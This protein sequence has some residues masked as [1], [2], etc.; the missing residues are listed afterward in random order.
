MALAFT[1]IVQ[2]VESEDLLVGGDKSK[3]LTIHH[4]FTGVGVE[5]LG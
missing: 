1:F 4:G 2:V 5:N 3:W